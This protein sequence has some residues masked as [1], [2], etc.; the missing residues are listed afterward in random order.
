MHGYSTVR[1]K[2]PLKGEGSRQRSRIEIMGACV[3]VT[4]TEHG[5]H[6]V[7]LAT[8]ITSGIILYTVFG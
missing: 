5:K 8:R 4:E 1:K 7:E 6:N 2:L 3:V